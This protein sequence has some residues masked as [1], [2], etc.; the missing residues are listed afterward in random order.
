MLKAMTSSPFTRVSCFTFPSRYCYAAHIWRP[1]SLTHLQEK[2]TSSYSPFKP[3]AILILR[4]PSDKLKHRP[5]KPNK[6]TNYSLTLLLMSGFPVL[7]QI[8]EGRTVCVYYAVRGVA[9]LETHGKDLTRKGHT[10]FAAMLCHH[11]YEYVYYVKIF[12][13]VN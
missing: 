2:Q 7:C 8:E 1:P 12:I 4:L 9:R 3:A 10:L 5:L 13:R 6:C 11:M